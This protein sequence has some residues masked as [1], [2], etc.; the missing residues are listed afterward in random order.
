MWRR[1]IPV[2]TCV[3]K[4]HVSLTQL[5]AVATDHT[6]CRNGMAWFRRVGGLLNRTYALKFELK[7]PGRYKGTFIENWGKDF[8][9]LKLSF[10]SH[11]SSQ[12]SRSGILDVAAVTFYCPWESL[13]LKI[14]NHTSLQ[15]LH[16]IVV[17]SVPTTQVRTP[18]VFRNWEVRTWGVWCNMYAKFCEDRKAVRTL[19]LNSTTPALCSEIV[20]LLH[21]TNLLY[22]TYAT[23][24]YFLGLVRSIYQT[25]VTRYP[26]LTVSERVPLNKKSNVHVTRIHVVAASDSGELCWT[27]AATALM[28]PSNF[29]LCP[30]LHL[31]GFTAQWISYMTLWK[32]L[33]IYLHLHHI[34]M[35]L[36]FSW[37]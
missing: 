7:L 14:Q 29:K 13:T 11:F 25:F 28:D 6:Y 2:V 33:V 26:I 37:L 4:E 18:P 35:N 19:S 10:R 12:G 3:G 31:P 34:H 8:S 30:T 1:I 5:R 17:N 27:N 21:H 15:G 24:I 36:Q 32:F 20:L 16:L 9:T 22:N 23:S